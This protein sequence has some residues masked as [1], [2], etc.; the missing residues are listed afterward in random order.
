VPQDFTRYKSMVLT[1]EPVA[2][3]KKV[4]ARPGTVLLQGTIGAPPAQAP[5]KK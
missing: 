2:N 1:R 4:P 5:A 3:P